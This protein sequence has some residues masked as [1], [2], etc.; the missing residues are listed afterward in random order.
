MIVMNKIKSLIESAESIL[1]LTHK[2]PDGDA[3]GSGLAFYNALV[4][5]NKIVDIVIDD[6]PR[7]F[8]FLSN[9]DKIK[10]TSKVEEY[11]LVVVVV[12][13]ANQE[14]IGQDNNY[15][16]NAKYTINIDHHV[17]NTNYANNNYVSGSSPA[18]CE[19][20]VEIFNELDI[21]I[22]KDIAECLMVGILTDTGGFQYPN[23]SEKTFN[24][25]SKMSNI[26]DIPYIYKN[27]LTTKTRSQFELSKVAI[28]RIELFGNDRIA[29][30]YLMKDD[31]EKVNA[32][33]G[34]HEGV[35]NIGREIEGVYVSIFV[36]EVDDGF[37]VSLRS[38]GNINVNEIASLFNGG[39]H[40]MAAGFDSNLE[41]DDLKNKIIESILDRIK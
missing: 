7:I 27:V 28:S 18:C 22:N 23:V 24:I 21:E 38:S 5:I 17:S 10:N 2:S 36:R 40:V 12:D 1:I 33:P 30:T 4:S 31:F 34:D 32:M 26:V 19:Y 35:V 11:D 14:R 25:A 16:E 29:F 13:C 6:V 3:V 37:R 41:F 39:G 20:L 8:G 15:F 9:Y